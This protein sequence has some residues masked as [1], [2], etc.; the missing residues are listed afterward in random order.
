MP[1]TAG[2]PFGTILEC[3]WIQIE[4][5]FHEE[6]CSVFCYVSNELS[7]LLQECCG[8]V[9]SSGLEESRAREARP[10]ILVVSKSVNDVSRG[11][12]TE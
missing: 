11:Q 4:G 10:E 9:Q 2:V 3:F 12:I 5:V 6:S 7:Q 1:C 8:I